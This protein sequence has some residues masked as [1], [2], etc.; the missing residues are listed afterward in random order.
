MKRL[1]YRPYWRYAIADAIAL[2]VSVLVVL[3]WFPL[4]TSVPFQKYSVFATIFAVMWL[5]ASYMC[6]RY[7]P[8]KYMKMGK[9]I[10]RLL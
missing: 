2:I 9:D 10:R 7:I 8:V 3:A 5:L 4:S 6:H 1:F